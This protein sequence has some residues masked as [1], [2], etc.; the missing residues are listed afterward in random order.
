MELYDTKPLHKLAD[1]TTNS[2]WN[3][4]VAIASL[5][6]G[7]RAQFPLTDSF[8]KSSWNKSRL[9][10]CLWHHSCN[11]LYALHVF[12]NNLKAKYP[13]KLQGINLTKAAQVLITFE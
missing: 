9:I 8:E 4:L 13:C 10:S 7:P 11:V 1:W 2:F 3:T 12:I 6:P 5:R